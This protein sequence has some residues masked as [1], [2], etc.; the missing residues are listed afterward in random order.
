M[1]QSLTPR[2]GASNGHTSSHSSPTKPYS[3]LHRGS[4]AVHNFVSP[5]AQVYQPLIVENTIA[6]ETSDKPPN[7]PI[8]YGAATRRRLYSIQAGRN[9][10][11]ETL[12][13][14]A[15]GSPL[16]KFPT[17]PNLPPG[18]SHTNKVLS[19]SPDQTPEFSS[20]NDQTRDVPSGSTS[21]P[22]SA[23]AEKA[24]EVEEW[25][26]NRAIQLSWAKRLTEIEKRQ[27]RI[28]SL[29]TQ[30]ARDIQGR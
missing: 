30:I 1:S 10:R 14:Y 3:L 18:S 19:R 15:R 7:S 25:I 24:P 5:L 13:H 23:T 27:E 2:Q 22:P 9:Q 20:G 16:E 29:L 8:S 21:A 12:T 26:D 17:L 28:E 6:E 11:S 4:D